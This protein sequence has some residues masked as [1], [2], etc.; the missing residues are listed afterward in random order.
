[1]ELD[2]I[3]LEVINNRLR[4]IGSTMEYLLYHSGYST[5]LRES[6]DGSAGICD[7][8]GYAIMASGSPLHLFPYYYSARAILQV[9]PREEMEDGDCFL[10]TDPYLGGIL[11]VPDLVILT[12]VFVEG[13]IIGFSISIA[14]KPDLGGIV[15]GSSGAAAREIFHDGLLVPG[16][17]YW[18][19]DGVVKDVEAII[20]RNCRIPDTVAGDIRAQIGCTKVGVQRI[21]ELCAEYGTSTITQAFAELQ[22]LAEQRVRRELA[23]WPD[24][25]AEAEGWVDDDGVDHDQPIRL[26]VKV[27]KRGDT[28]TFDYSGMNP[29][30][31][32]PINLRPQSSETAAVLAVLA[33]LDPTITIND[34]IRRA[35][36]FVNP[37]GT[38]TNARWP[39]AVNSYFGLTNV[40]YSTVGKALAQ[41]NPRRA[42]GSAGFGLG[43][44][45]VGH[46]RNR[47]G[48]SSVQYELFVTA[49]GGTPDHDGPDGTVGMLTATPNTPVEI[50]ETEFPV[51]VRR[52]EWTRDSAGAGRFRGGIGNCKEYE[53]LGDTVLTLRLGHQFKYS[54][55]GVFGGKAPPTSRAT[56]NPGTPDERALQP[57]ETLHL[58]AGDSFR[59]EMPGGG[60]YGDPR[61]REPERV[62]DDVLNGYVSIEAAER[63]Y[64]VAI[65]LPTRTVDAART[66]RLRG[67]PAA[68]PDAEP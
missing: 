63:D 41:F 52:H 45:A 61:E 66:A 15:P 30:V 44:I 48:K 47:A 19:K 26:H 65:D 67:D 42:T 29:Q 11:H 12:P 39:A 21:R 58:Q 2:P 7:R 50:I 28:I 23:A 37:E 24:G 62:L 38:I 60:G 1:M 4:E 10:L 64:G 53:L 35:I 51:R 68:D 54:G 40:L 18:T 22:R 13:E 9:Y 20:K 57:L 55:W 3:T 32:G 6:H 56:L 33:H 34:G 49:H 16:V 36:S 5:I 8:E 59:V 27:I 14:H 46:Q 17:R 43:A 25:E 31:K